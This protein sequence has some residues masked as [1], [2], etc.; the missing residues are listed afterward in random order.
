[1]VRSITTVSEKLL[2][3][4]AVKFVGTATIGVDHVDLAY[5]QQQ[6]IEFASAPGVMPRQPLNMSSVP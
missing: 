1:M 2:T 3:G 5:L 6:H 4:S